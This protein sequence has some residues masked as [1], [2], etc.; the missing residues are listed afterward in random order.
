MLMPA[1]LALYCVSGSNPTNVYFLRP[2]SF[3]VLFC[4]TMSLAEESTSLQ[5]VRGEVVAG[6]IGGSYKI[7]TYMQQY[8]C[9]HPEIR[10]PLVYRTFHFV[11][12][13][14]AII[15]PLKSG[16]LSDQDTFFRSQRCPHF[17]VCCTC[18]SLCAYFP[19]D[20]EC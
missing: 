17:E 3:S 18:T 12:M 10:T 1:T 15:S 6:T 9:G 13:H 5:P 11:P 14:V 4:S 19:L 8:M 2:G 20:I 7:Y 16:Y